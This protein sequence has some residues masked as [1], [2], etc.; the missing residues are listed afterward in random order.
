MAK[1]KGKKPDGKTKVSYESGDIDKP[2]KKKKKK[3]KPAVGEVID[4]AD[5]STAEA[6]DPAAEEKGGA[7]TPAVAPIISTPSD[8]HGTCKD[9]QGPVDVVVDPFQ[10][11]GKNEMLCIGCRAERIRT[12]A[13]EDKAK[14]QDKAD[15]AIAKL[16]D[17]AKE[18]RGNLQDNNLEFPTK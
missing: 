3:G 7:A 11:V 16:E 9:C 1:G 2:A 14:V 8:N 12:R 17:D 6:V 4:N 18:A 5:G 10:V 15:L 13:V